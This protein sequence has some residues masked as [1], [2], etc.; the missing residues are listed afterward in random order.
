[1]SLN[2]LLGGIHIHKSNCVAKGISTEKFNKYYLIVNCPYC[3]S[4]FAAHIKEINT[5]QNGTKVIECICCHK[6]IKVTNDSKFING[7]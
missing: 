7:K 3:N 4:E 2:A 6:D 5:L 1:M